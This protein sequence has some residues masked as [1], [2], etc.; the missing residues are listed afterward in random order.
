MTDEII[1]K[2]VTADEKTKVLSDGGGQII[3]FVVPLSYSL[4]YNGYNNTTP[5][6][7]PPPY[8]SQSRD[9]VLRSMVHFEPMWAASVHIAI[10]K[11]VTQAWQVTSSVP[12][13]AKRAQDILLNFGGKRNGWVT[14]L[15]KGLRDFLNTDNGQFIEIVRTGKSPGHRI[16]GLMPLDSCRCT[17]T[18]DPQYP[19]IYRDRLGKYHALKDY[20]VMMMS[21]MP[22]PGD[23]YFGV[24]LSATARA[25][26]E[27]WKLMMITWYINE[28]VS[29]M[30]PLEIHIVNGLIGTQLEDAVESAKQKQV[31]KGVVSY[32]GAV[33]VSNPSTVPPEIVSI[34]LAEL[35]DR[36]NRKEEFDI[37]LLTY[38]NCLGLD[39]QDL[40]PLSSQALGSGSQ[41]QILEEKSKGKGVAAWRQDFTHQLNMYVLDDITEFIFIEKDYKDQKAQTDIAYQQAQ[42]AEK[43]I[44]SGITT[45]DMELQ[46][47]VE[48]QEIP[49]ELVPEDDIDTES[50]TDTEKP[51]MVDEQQEDA[52]EEKPQFEAKEASLFEPVD[53]E[54]DID[55]QQEAYQLLKEAADA[56]A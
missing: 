53:S 10:T 23:T 6:P 7:N 48:R 12:L 56:V 18:G 52:Q 28:K 19:V 13:R 9:A 34:P 35:P 38:A 20:Q 36:F 54:N 8:W 16:V 51:D 49:K 47:M 3:R 21:D 2:S 50:V 43:R 46:I 37:A 45:A 55:Y 39:P 30:Q 29:G 11:L 24:G 42:V 31:G 15:S 22:D 17:R 32:M 1:R 41:S 27:I 25:Y 33:I 40:Q 5:P 14:S 26:T 4:G 44:G